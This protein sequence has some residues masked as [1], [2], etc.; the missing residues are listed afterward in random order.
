MKMT[1]DEVIESLASITNTSCYYVKQ[2][3]EN[4]KNTSLNYQK[5]EYL[6]IKEKQE[7]A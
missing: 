6:N 7:N 5:L 4:L 1:E 3:F 2:I